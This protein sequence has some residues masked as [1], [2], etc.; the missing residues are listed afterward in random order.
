MSVAEA[1]DAT[2]ALDAPLIDLDRIRTAP[3]MHEPLRA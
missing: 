3:V 2:A 1:L